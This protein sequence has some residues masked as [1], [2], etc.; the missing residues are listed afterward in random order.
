MKLQSYGQ[1]VFMYFQSVKQVTYSEPVDEW[2]PQLCWSYSWPG[3]R[4][5]LCR[6]CQ[7]H[8]GGGKTNHQVEQVAEDPARSWL[9]GLFDNKF[10]MSPAVSGF[11]VKFPP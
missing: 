4:T 8:A 1:Q 9:S 3:R 2:Q 10:C 7:P 5:P 6:L 11:S